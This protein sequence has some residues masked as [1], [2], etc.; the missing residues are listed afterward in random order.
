MTDNAPNMIKALRDINK[1]KEDELAD[2]ED[3]DGDEDQLTSDSPLLEVDTEEEIEQVRRET[4]AL[5]QQ[6]DDIESVPPP[7]G[8]TRMGCVAHKVRL[9]LF[10]YDLFNLNLDSLGNGGHSQESDAFF[11]S[12]N[13]EGPKVHYEVSHESKSEVHVV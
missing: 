9:V 7:E 1:I 5:K 2:H 8:M 3:Q 13:Q 4:E 11:W 12:T 10:S 6:L